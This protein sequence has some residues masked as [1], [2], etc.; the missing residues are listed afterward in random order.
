MSLEIISDEEIQLERESYLCQSLGITSVARI[1]RQE[2][3]Q[4]SKLQNFLNKI[5][6]IDEDYDKILFYVNS[7]E[8]INKDFSIKGKDADM[9]FNGEKNNILSIKYNLYR[10]SDNYLKKE[11]S[12]NEINLRKYH[13]FFFKV[14]LP[15][16]PNDKSIESNRVKII[17][18][19]QE[20]DTK[21]NFVLEGG[22]DICPRGRGII[23]EL[24]TISAYKFK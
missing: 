3:I 5:F 24:P 20:D 4:A 22:V 1:S 17:G 19:R 2:K 15:E 21:L 10:L 9:T 6:L 12:P 16:N 13:S 7:F 23:Y 14:E 18:E 11:V 8:I